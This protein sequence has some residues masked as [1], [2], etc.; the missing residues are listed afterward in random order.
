M[1]QRNVVQLIEAWEAATKENPL[2][3]RADE[4]DNF[5]KAMDELGRRYDKKSN[6]SKMTIQDKDILLKDGVISPADG[7]AYHNRK[8]WNEHLHSRGLVEFGNDRVNK[9]KPR[10]IQMKD[11]NLKS[12]IKQAVNQVKTQQDYR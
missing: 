4:C 2:V 3:L 10:Q 6:V 7:K 8:E 9:D 11:M 1:A 5:C 12:A